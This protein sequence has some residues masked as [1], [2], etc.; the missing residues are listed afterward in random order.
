MVGIYKITNLIN[1]KCYIGQSLNISRRIYDHF[2]RSQ[3]ENS[4]AY[5]ALLHQA[6]RKYGKENFEWE[7][8]KKCNAGE[9]DKLEKKYIQEYNSI[10]P[11][12]YNIMLGGQKNRTIPKYFCQNCGKILNY[13][14]QYCWD[15]YIIEE[16]TVERPSRQELKDLIRTLPFTVIGKQYGV[17]DNAIRKWCKRE[18]L[19]F[20]SREIQKYSDEEWNNI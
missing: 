7:V 16:R 11:N 18:G 4:N 13:N 10:T 20:K 14:T 2:Y 8:I 5:N 15:C 6:I 12:G 19:P 1:G 9:L 3:D 17:T